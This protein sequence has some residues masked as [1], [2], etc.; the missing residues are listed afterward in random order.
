M[1]CERERGKRFYV[2][3]RDNGATFYTP[4][5]SISAATHGKRE[6]AGDRR[7]PMYL[8]VRDEEKGLIYKGMRRSGRPDPL[9][10]CHGERIF[11]RRG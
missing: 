6:R 11:D 4:L 8:R 9:F 10:A 7:A 5:G 1:H 2:L 3:F